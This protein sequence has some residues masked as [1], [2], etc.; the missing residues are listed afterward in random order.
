MRDKT[1]LKKLDFENGMG[2]FIYPKK[3]F[4]P[5]TLPWTAQNFRR[6]ENKVICWQQWSVGI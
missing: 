2:V 3:N 1:L 6:V 4:Q 5:C